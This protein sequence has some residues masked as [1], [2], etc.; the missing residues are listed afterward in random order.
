[1]ASPSVI[2]VDEAGFGADVLERSRRVPVVV[3]FW[4]DWCQPCRVL[5]PALEEAVEARGGDVVLAKVDVDHN[6]GLAQRW[7][8]Q[9]IPAVKAFRDGEVVA[10]FTGAVGRSAI[11]DFL[12]SIVPSQADRIAAAARELAG[13]EPEKAASE[14]RRALDLD[15]GHRGAAVGLAELLVDEDPD[16]A[17]E[18][19]RPHRPDPAAEAVATRADLVRAADVDVEELRRRVAGDPGDGEAHLLLGR[20]LAARERYEEAVEHLLEAVRT[21]GEVRE[22][23]RERLV[24]IFGV[25]GEDH[26]LTR[27]ARRWLAS[28]LF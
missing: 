21:G 13:T 14:L 1:M 25:L 4:A 27:R 18:L 22:P 17:D 23:A 19:I 10:E 7:G 11:E 3:D 5:G 2:D 24:G 28:A 26:D 9:G 16:A 15:P 12:D 20:T 6:R 8:I